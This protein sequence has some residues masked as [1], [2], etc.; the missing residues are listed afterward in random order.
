MFCG[1]FFCAKLLKRFEAK[2]ILVVSL[3]LQ[4]PFFVSL[5]LL[6]FSSSPTAIWFFLT[7]TA[8]Y[9]FTSLV[10]ATSVFFAT[11]ATTDKANGSSMMSFIIMASA[12]ISVIVL[13]YLPFSSLPAFIVVLV[14]TYVFV[15]LISWKRLIT[16]FY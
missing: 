4:I 7:T 11:S 3:L 1:G 6:F 13:G 14:V 15:I 5:I 16:F 10:F 8:L 2:T 12:M 9:F